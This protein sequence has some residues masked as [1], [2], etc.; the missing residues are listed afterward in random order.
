LNDDRAAA[1]GVV[2][3]QLR[4]RVD[5]ADWDAA[6][7]IL[8][9]QWGAILAE[10]PGLIVSTVKAAKWFEEQPA[11]GVEGLVVKGGG[12]GTREGRACG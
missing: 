3:A 8:D 7:T 12:S 6:V 10:D 9:Q 5:A 2:G 11:T 1:D 4:A